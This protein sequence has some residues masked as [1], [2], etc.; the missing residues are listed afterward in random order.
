M[1]AVKIK[2]RNLTKEFYSFSRGRVLALENF[3]LDIGAGEFFV[4][5]GPSGSG[6]ST[7]L[8]LI[9]GLEE[10]NQGEIWFDERKV[11]C[12]LERIFLTPSE[13]GV[14][15]VFQ[16]YALYPHLKVSEN[17]AFPLRMEGL[18]QAEIKTRI[19]KVA[20][21]LE[22]SSLLCV[23]PRELSGGQRQRVAI[24]RAIVRNPTVFL[25]DEPLSNLDAQLRVRMRTQLK[26]LQRRLN[27]TTLY[28]THD[29]VEAMT[30]A[31]RIA[32]LKEGRIQQIGS[33]IEVYHKPLNTF[34]ASFLGTPSMNLLNAR[35]CQQ[36][37][38]IFIK[39]DNCR[40]KLPPAYRE[41]LG[42]LEG[43]EFILGIRP[44]DIKLLPYESREGFSAV[45]ENVEPLGNEMLLHFRI[46]GGK[47]IARLSEYEEFKIGESFNIAVEFDKIHLFDKEGRRLGNSP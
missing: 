2:I 27:V 21:M 7:F 34:V 20:R 24:A 46:N 17:I 9:A 31:D 29:Q 41:S 22:I 30:L 11:F 18:P 28:V 1:D 42:R 32:I 26:N 14:A 4:I 16:S 12:F 13:R 6:K 35:L 40:L 19:E 3:N 37:T 8:N 10:A 36:G 33:P 5:L 15:M 23:K 44:E 45:L 47:I 43:R 39:I 38:E 25:L